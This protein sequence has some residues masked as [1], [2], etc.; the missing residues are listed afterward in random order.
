MPHRRSRY[1]RRCCPALAVP[2]GLQAICKLRSTAPP[3]ERRCPRLSNRAQVGKATR[4]SRRR[5]PMLCS[6][7]PART[8]AR[9]APSLQ[10]L[11]AGLWQCPPCVCCLASYH[12]T[13]SYFPRRSKHR[14][15]PIVQCKCWEWQAQCPMHTRG[16]QPGCRAVN[17]D[18]AVASLQDRASAPLLA[19]ARAAGLR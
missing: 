12:T 9:R 8:P 18:L 6:D 5:Q 13:I 2:P 7:M 3:R 16:L 17:C 10:G 1:R 19:P 14:E 4:N 15:M 11:G